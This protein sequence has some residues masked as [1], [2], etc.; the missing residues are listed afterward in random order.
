MI[1]I[2]KY[3]IR[4]F[5]ITVPMP[6]WATCYAID[7]DGSVY[8]YE[9]KPEVDEDEDDTMWIANGRIEFSGII[10]EPHLFGDWRET[11]HEIKRSA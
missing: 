4:E 11:L 2:S 1:S 6:E 3:Y 9:E 5:L 7:E 10:L 8:L